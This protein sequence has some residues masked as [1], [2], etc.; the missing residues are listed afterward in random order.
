M[1]STQSKRRGRGSSGVQGRIYRYLHQLDGAFCSKQDLAKAL[2]LSLPTVYQNLNELTDRGLVG[3][4]GQQQ[5]TGGRYAN[6]LTVIPDARLAVGVAVTETHLRLAVT[7]LHL[8]QLAYKETDFTPI[9]GSGPALAEALEIFLDEHRIDRTRLLGV[10]V[11][12]PGVLSADKQRLLLAPTLQMQDVS[13]E[14]LYRAIPYP[15]HVDND[16]NCGGHAE[17]FIRD[18]QP[19]M[20]YLSLE[21]GVGGAILIGD[22]LYTGTS[23][24]SGEF[25]HM[26]V[27]PGGLAC[28][29]GR[30]GCLEAYCSVRRI[31]SEGY[32]VEDFFDRVEKH[33]MLCQAL[34]GDML[35]HLAIGINNIHMALDCDVILGGYLS[36]YIEDWF[37][38]L[39]R[40]VAA[41]SLGG[42]AESVHL[43]LLRP[44]SSVLGAACHFIQE[45]IMSI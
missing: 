45:F 41:G 25:G 30:R 17:W 23:Q 43:S 13:L 22:R 1:Q 11:A 40:H 26:C 36:G 15:L 19:N 3:Y 12:I 33:D 24:R 6:G 32:S 37:P 31:R 18:H 16:A 39:Q 44:H 8:R 34:W 28:S 9:P 29:C 20:A 7:D 27:E 2:G 10:G 4:S 5:A 38:E 35:R 14:E 42:G 21:S